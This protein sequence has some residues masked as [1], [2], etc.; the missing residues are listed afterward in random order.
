MCVQCECRQGAVHVRNTRLTRIEKVQAIPL[1][2]ESSII[3]P[4]SPKTFFVTIYQPT[5]WKAGGRS[6]CKMACSR[7][8]D[9]K[10][11][12]H[13]AKHQNVCLRWL[14]YACKDLTFVITPLSSI[15]KRHQIQECCPGRVLTEITENVWGAERPFKW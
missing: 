3:H 14:P 1:N 12:A 11:Q 9:G 10:R 4:L 6:C 7:E 13:N 2:C 5:V 15:L 8:P